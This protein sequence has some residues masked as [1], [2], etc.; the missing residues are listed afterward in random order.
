MAG[1]RRS[2]AITGRTT[3][4]HPRRS[5]A[6]RPASAPRRSAL[7]NA[8]R[9]LA[10]RD[11][12]SYDLRA[13]LLRS[14]FSSAEVNEVIDRLHRWHLVD[15]ESFAERFA[16]R[17]LRLR[18]D[19]PRK[20]R[21]ALARQGIPPQTAAAGLE[22]ALDET[23]EDS[24]IAALAG[25]IWRRKTSLMPP[26]RLAYVYSRLLRRGFSQQ[27][28]AVQLRRLHPELLDVVDEM[29]SDFDSTPEEDD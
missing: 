11:R 4:S 28:I 25:D 29:Q 17:G 2:R 3:R 9:L 5:S 7:Q 21:F 24:A 8:L 22:R 13:S 18:K 10:L 19:G 20:I 27:R 1:P 26:R 15:D 6:A 16:S 12:S 14:G 23:A